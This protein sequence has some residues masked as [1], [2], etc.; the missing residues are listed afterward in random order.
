MKDA[1]NQRS[2]VVLDILE[3]V[4]SVNG[5]IDLH[6]DDDFMREQYEHRKKELTARL[7]EKLKAYDV[8]IE[9]IAA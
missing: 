3:Q 8:A 6:R 2:L 1:T 9:E 5:M 7:V 4:E